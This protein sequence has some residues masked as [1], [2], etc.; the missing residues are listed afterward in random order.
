MQESLTCGAEVLRSSK[1]EVLCWR[2]LQVRD[3]HTG[4]SYKRADLLGDAR[5]LH[6]PSSPCQH[7][8]TIRGWNNTELSF[9]R[10]EILVSCSMCLRTAGSHKWEMMFGFVANWAESSSPT[11]ESM[12]ALLTLVFLCH[13]S[14]LSWLQYT[15]DLQCKR[16]CVCPTILTFS[17]QSRYFSVVSVEEIYRFIKVKRNK[18]FQQ[19]CL[20][21]KERALGDNRC[22]LPSISAAWQQ[23]KAVKT[24]RIS[25]TPKIILIFWFLVLLLSF[26]AVD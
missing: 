18:C 2:R 14:Y 3:T 21:A 8:V 12:L 11:P 24:L 7:V 5:L 17:K 13:S 1:C 20:V 16:A 26:T 25:S 15:P 22:G 4:G 9:S 6:A 10:N 19:R 23:G